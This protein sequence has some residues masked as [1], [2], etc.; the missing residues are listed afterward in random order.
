M[1]SPYPWRC[2]APA[3]GENDEAFDWLE[4]AYEGHNSWLP[5]LRIDPCIDPLRGDPRLDNL[6]EGR[7][8]GLKRTRYSDTRS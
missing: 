8:A 7:A 2:C 6:I 5:F 4:R 3:L 1:E